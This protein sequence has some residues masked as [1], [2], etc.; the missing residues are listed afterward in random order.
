MQMF[1][2][3]V[4]IDVHLCFCWASFAYAGEMLHAGRQIMRISQY[5]IVLT[6]FFMGVLVTPRTCPTAFSSNCLS[7]PS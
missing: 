6:G 4:E 5:I 1:R 3:R 2:W 7:L